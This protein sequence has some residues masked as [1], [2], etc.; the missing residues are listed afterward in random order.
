MLPPGLRLPS[1]C[2][3]LLLLLEGLHVDDKVELAE[4]VRVVP[5]GVGGGHEHLLLGHLAL[6]R[7]HGAGDH[8]FELGS[9][10]S[11]VSVEEG[12]GVGV[13]GRHAVRADVLDVGDHYIAVIGS[14][15]A[16]G[17]DVLDHEPEHV[18]VPLKDKVP[19]VAF[20]EL[21]GAVKE[22]TAGA[23][24]GRVDVVVGPEV[25]DHH[26][27]GPLERALAVKGA[28]ELEVV[29]APLV[30]ALLV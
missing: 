22:N 1:L 5:G 10:P 9:G 18:S 16:V 4:L 20:G 27:E 11:A 6:Y 29:A 8:A 14:A 19:E 25:G 15:D 21:L 3:L 28:L 26:C 12:E 24:G 2:S 23:D 13:L 30:L 7:L 17:V